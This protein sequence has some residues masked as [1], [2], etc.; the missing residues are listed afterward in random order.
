[1]RGQLSEE[2]RPY[3]QEVLSGAFAKL[4]APFVHVRSSTNRSGVSL[5]IRETLPLAMM[6][7][8]KFA[9]GNPCEEP[10]ILVGCSHHQRIGED[11]VWM[12]AADC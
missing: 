12:L 1:M 8:S 4:S 10:E 2:S 9:H 6:P 7:R 11:S 3:P 5:S